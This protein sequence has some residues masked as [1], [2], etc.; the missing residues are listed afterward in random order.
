MCIVGKQP[1]AR[2]IFETLK[3]APVA[4]E[5]KRKVRGLLQSADGSLRTIYG[6]VYKVAQSYGFIRADLAGIETYFD[7]SQETEILEA[8]QKDD[9]VSFNLG[10]TL[11]GP[12]AINVN[13]V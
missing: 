8:A 3:H 1:E 9:R 11:A 6:V 10:F 7:F 5:Q 4:Y 2:Q 13:P 12:C